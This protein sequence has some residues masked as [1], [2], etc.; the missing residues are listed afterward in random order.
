MAPEAADHADVD[1]EVVRTS[2]PQGCTGL[3]QVSGHQGRVSDKPEFDR[4]YVQH[5]TLRLDAWILWRTLCQVVA[6]TMI[7][8]S[9]VPAWTLRQPELAVP[10]DAA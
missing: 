10:A 7:E 1:Y 9:D 2:V 5:Q 6:P 3:W 4:F 8:L